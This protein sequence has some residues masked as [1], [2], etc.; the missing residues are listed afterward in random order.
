[1]TLL[2]AAFETEDSNVVLFAILCS[3]C[4]NDVV[5]R[6]HT[7]HWT[8]PLRFP[9]GSCEFCMDEARQAI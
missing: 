3:G 5:A 4:L 1:M 6:G 7:R 2:R 8:A 9:Q